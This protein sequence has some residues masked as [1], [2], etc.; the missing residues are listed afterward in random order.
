MSRYIAL[1]GIDGAG[2]TSVL[3]ALAERLEGEGHDVVC[4]REPGGTAVGE[5]LRD[6]LLEGPPMSAWAEAL[7]FA[8]DRAQLVE[9]V[10]RPALARSAWVLSDRSVYSSLAYQGAGRGLG[11]G[12]V[13]QINEPG[14]SGTWPDMVM[15]LV[16]APEAGLARQEKEDRIGSE[17]SSL[18]ASVAEAFERLASREPDRFVVID[19]EQSLGLVVD[20][21]WAA[22][23]L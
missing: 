20:Q 9:E 8:A 1:E 14:L 2:K 19:A 13:R 10:V 6:L 4:V 17:G 18:L 11:I 12:R 15:L 5:S 22:V 16:V 21:A 23:Q 3:V 7:M